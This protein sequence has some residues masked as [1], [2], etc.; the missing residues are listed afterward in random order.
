MK[1]RIAVVAIAALM[2]GSLT[3]VGAVSAAEPTE[4][5]FWH[6]MSEDKEGKFVNEAIEEFNNSQDEVHVT[7]QYL[8]RE[9]LMKQYTIGVVSG[10]LPDCGMVDNPDH[11]SYA[12]MGVFEDITDLYNSWMKQI[13]WKDPLTPV[14][15][16]INFM[17][18]L[19]EI[20]VW[21]FSIINLCWKR[22]E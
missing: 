19:G 13:L 22:Q 6:Y 2:A 20:T 14:I 7:A 11:A 18:Y 1:K 15:M 17:D 10:E 9:E 16:T 5:T 21:D 12:S 3:N 4:I 8:P